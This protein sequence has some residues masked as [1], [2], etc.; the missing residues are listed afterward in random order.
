MA[1]L[2]LDHR[3]P[4]QLRALATVLIDLLTPGLEQERG[5]RRLMAEAERRLRRA[6]KEGL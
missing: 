5:R 2:D 4:D 3:T 6:A 1:D